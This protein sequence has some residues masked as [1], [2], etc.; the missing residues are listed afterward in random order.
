MNDII[1][2][3]VVTRK[4]AIDRAVGFLKTAPSPNMIPSTTQF[5]KGIAGIIMFSSDKTKDVV[6]AKE[7]AFFPIYPEY[8]YETLLLRDI[9]DFVY[10]YDRMQGDIFYANDVYTHT[11]YVVGEGICGIVSD[12]LLQSKLVA[13]CVEK[14]KKNTDNFFSTLFLE[15]SNKLLNPDGKDFKIETKNTQEKP[16]TLFSPVIDAKELFIYDRLG[17]I[18][19]Y[20]TH[21]VT[22]VKN[23]DCFLLL[24]TSENKYVRVRRNI[25]GYNSTKIMLEGCLY[26]TNQQL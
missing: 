21:S 4:E 1:K 14:L 20:E 24:C 2:H 23:N 11:N 12:M 25:M 15:I 22:V 16:L 10:F 9:V 3:K 5:N 6:K 19:F 26:E 7:H 18:N 8:Q 13:K 17:I